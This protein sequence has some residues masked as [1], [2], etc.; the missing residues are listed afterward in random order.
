MKVLRDGFWLSC[1]SDLHCTLPVLPRSFSIPSVFSPPPPSLVLV[2]CFFSFSFLFF[3]FL[4]FL[5]LSLSFSF[6]LFV[7]LTLVCGLSSS[8][9]V[10]SFFL[11]S[12]Y[13]KSSMFFVLC[14]LSVCVCARLLSNR[15]FSSTLR[16][17]QRQDALAL[18][19]SLRQKEKQ[20]QTDLALLMAQFEQQQ[21][22]IN[23]KAEEMMVRQEVKRRNQ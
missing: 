22:A 5:S 8:N 18:I 20:A 11:L 16:A 17:R 6:R 21:Q 19:A 10:S 9:H 7:V 3:S 23:K 2:S 4:F 1:Q 15:R 14:A 13:S 12:C